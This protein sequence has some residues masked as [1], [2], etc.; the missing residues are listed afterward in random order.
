MFI[1]INAKADVQGSKKGKLTHTQ[2]AQLNAWCLASKTGILDCLGKC[3]YDTQ[4][5]SLVVINNKVDIVFKSGYVVICGRL[6]E[7]EEGTIFTLDNLANEQEGSIVLRYNLE[8]SGEQEFVITKK[9]GVLDDQDLNEYPLTGKY[10]FELYSYKVQ[11]NT[12]VLTRSMKYVSNLESLFDKNNAV[13]VQKARNFDKDVDE[14][15]EHGELYLRFAQIGISN[16]KGTKAIAP[17]NGYNKDKGTIEERLTNLGF[18]SGV[19][20]FLGDNYGSENYI[21][22]TQNGIYRIGNFVIC[23]VGTIQSNKGSYLKKNATIFTLPTNF[24]PKYPINVDLIAMIGNNPSV[25]KYMRV[26]IDKNGNGV[27]KATG[28]GS[29]LGDTNL[30]FEYSLNFGFEAPPIT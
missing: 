5:T 19:I 22:A 15:G 2:N 6:V 27:V 9:I 16:Y 4:Q 23:H 14:N 7:C 25:A 8:N 28:N 12:V 17:L 20:N 21:N 26:N 11:S 29:N 18:K 30:D 10:D 24:R 1:P 13:A 3:E